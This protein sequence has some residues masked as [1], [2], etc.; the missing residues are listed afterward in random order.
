VFR[1]LRVKEDSPKIAPGLDD[2]SI[3]QL[4]DD[5]SIPVTLTVLNSLPEN[6]KLRLYRTLLP[7]QVLADFDINLRTWKNPDKAPQ[8]KL[9]AEKGSN[10]VKLSAWYGESTENE[11]FY[12]ELA[13]NA[14]NG[15]DLNFFIANNQSA[16]DMILIL[17]NREE[18]R[19][20][21]LSTET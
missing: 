1:K 15:V 5:A 20:S 2:I 19:I 17:M 14:F 11:F 6:P 8:V 10:K 12:L 13:D 3:V 4:I 18:K 9:V 16:K 7:I 21:A